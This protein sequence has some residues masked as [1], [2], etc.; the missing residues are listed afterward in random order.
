MKRPLHRPYW[1]TRSWHTARPSEFGANP[2]RLTQLD[3]Y[4]QGV[5]NLLS[6][7]IL[8]S[9]HILF[10]EYY[11][12]GEQK[13]YHNVNSITKSVTSTLVGIALQE[14][15]LAHLEQ[16][17]LSF[18][19]DYA[20]RL[21]DPRKQAITLRHLL[22]M[23]SGYRPSPDDVV[24]FLEDTSSTE[25]MLQRPLLST[26]GITYAYDDVSLHFLALILPSITHLS[27]ASY[28][29]SRLFE[30]LG[31]WQDEEGS[32][33]PWKRGTFT[34]EAPHPFGLWN[35]DDD[36]LWSVDRRGYYIAS[37]GLQLTT[38]EMAKFGYLWL[39]RGHWDGQQLLPE[40]YLHDAWT[41][42]SITPQGDGYGYLW[43]LPEYNGYRV[44]CA[45]G[46]GGQL[47]AVVSDLDLVVAITMDPPLIP[48]GPALP[49][50]LLQKFVLPAFHDEKKPG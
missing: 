44:P 15:H 8:R 46:Y 14:G 32:T 25:K 34:K 7:L 19:P 10:E 20:S 2:E 43:F 6:I 1:P 27:L 13:N 41:A 37:F 16:T 28:G 21:D 40:A 23:S 3:Q 11:H 12:G 17:L 31:I 33:Q 29:R 22:S 49:P 9:G 4:I 24:T 30:P 47:I 48:Q 5:D 42:H 38:R 18:F 45:V 35:N 26:P 50:L 36:A 39:N